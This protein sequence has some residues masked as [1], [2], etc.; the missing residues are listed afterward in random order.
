MGDP[1]AEDT[2][3]GPQARHDLR[4][5]LLFAR[6]QVRRLRFGRERRTHATLD[7]KGEAVPAIGARLSKSLRSLEL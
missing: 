1:M 3:L 5:E 4:D 2:Q 7:E 6:G